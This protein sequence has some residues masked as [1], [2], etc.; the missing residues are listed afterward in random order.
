MNLLKRWFSVAMLL[1]LI[2]SS[3]FAASVEFTKNYNL[4]ECTFQDSG[5]NKFFSLVVGAQSTF[6]G[7]EG[8]LNVRLII[9]VLNET[10]TININGRSISTRVIEEREWQNGVI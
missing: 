3:S 5:A 4:N 2:P 9:S 10:K 7:L 6:E 8:K 1:V